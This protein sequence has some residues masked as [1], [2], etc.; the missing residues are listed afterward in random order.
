MNDSKSN[1]NQIEISKELQQLINDGCSFEDAQKALL[2]STAQNDH[3][4]HDEMPKNL[5][6][7]PKSKVSN[8]CFPDNYV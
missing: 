5:M 2:M 8:Q 4:N 6:N 3:K 1:Y 7:E